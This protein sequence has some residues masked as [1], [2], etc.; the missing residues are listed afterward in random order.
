[1]RGTAGIRHSRRSCWPAHP[2]RTCC[3]AVSSL[4][5][6]R[7][8]EDAVPNR[9]DTGGALVHGASDNVRA[10][11]RYERRVHAQH[12]GHDR[13]AASAHPRTNGNTSAA[14]CSTACTARANGFTASTA[15]FTASTAGFATATAGFTR[16]PHMLMR[17]H[18]WTPSI[19]VSQC[20]TETRENSLSHHK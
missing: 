20:T 19:D 2:R 5:G 6:S 1:M 11:P 15:G 4:R 7:R 16:E 9:V 18:R 17:S 8:Q 13:T 12:D 3:I 14:A 10:A